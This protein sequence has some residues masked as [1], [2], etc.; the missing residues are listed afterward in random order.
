[1]LDMGGGAQFGVQSSQ[2]C[3]GESGAEVRR[4]LALRRRFDVAQHVARPPPG[5]EAR[6][7]LRRDRE[8]GVRQLLSRHVGDDRLAVDQNAVAVEDE[9]G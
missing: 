7:D 8:S 4:Q 6:H 1:M 3:G 9:H 2:R 5:E